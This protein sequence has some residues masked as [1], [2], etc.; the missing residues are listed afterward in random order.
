MPRIMYDSTNLYDIPRTAQAIAYYVDGA[1]AAPQAAIDWHGAPV[2]V[3]ITVTGGTLAAQVCDMENGDLTPAQAA[4]WIKRKIAAGQ[5]PTA[6]F[7]VSRWPALD[8]ARKALGIPD[9]S[10]SVWT[11]DW[12][13][14]PHLTTNA[15]ATQYADPAYGSGGHYDLSLLADYWPGVDGPAGYSLIDTWAHAQALLAQGVTLYYLDASGH[16]LVWS[17]ALHLPAGTHLYYVPS[18]VPVPPTP[19]PGPTPAPSP[20][21]VPPAPAPAPGPL[22]A[23]P[24]PPVSP[25]DPAAAQQSFYG[26]LAGV[27]GQDIPKMLQDIADQLRKLSGV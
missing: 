4:D 25:S 23:P 21:P 26:W 1:Y 3:G 20:I 12:T 9:G 11:A 5:H 18:S 14:K 27:L 17:A 2:K 7:S 8:A 6:Y 22:P 13:G 15:A 19:T 24:P 16:P 10:F